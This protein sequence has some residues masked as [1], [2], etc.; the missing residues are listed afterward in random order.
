MNPTVASR[1]VAKLYV[2]W[3][4]FRSQQDGVRPTIAGF[5]IAKNLARIVDSNGTRDGEAGGDGN[6]R[7]GRRFPLMS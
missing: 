7:R 2:V 5:G 4:L 6:P 3:N 1:R